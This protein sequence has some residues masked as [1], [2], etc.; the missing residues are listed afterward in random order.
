MFLY[1]ENVGSAD[2]HL[3]LIR[4]FPEMNKLHFKEEKIF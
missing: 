1:Y 2:M 3:Y 4:I